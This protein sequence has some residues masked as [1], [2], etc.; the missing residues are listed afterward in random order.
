M[1]VY[2]LA[3]DGSVASASTVIVLPSGSRSDAAPLVCALAADDWSAAS[4]AAPIAVARRR[5][6]RNEFRV[7]LGL[8]VWPVL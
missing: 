5:R 7:N 6:A 1:S 3:L 4:R 2:K 8:T